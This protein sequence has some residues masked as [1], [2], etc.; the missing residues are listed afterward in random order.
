[1]ADPELFKKQ[2]NI[3]LPY[4]NRADEMNTTNPKVAYYCRMCAVVKGIELGESN[5]DPQIKDILRLV[6]DKMEKDKPSLGINPVSDPVECEMWAKLVFT[7]ADKRD[8]A[9][10]SD[11]TTRT[12][13]YN[14]YQFYD[15]ASHVGPLSAEGQTL[16]RY[17]AF[18]ATQIQKALRAGLPPPPPVPIDAEALG[19]EAEEDLMEALNSLPGEL[20]GIY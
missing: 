19:H 13:F 3:L 7:T 11:S 9:G 18:R 1:M 8:R 16:Q 2:K 10:A 4:L 15:V 6:A 5:L 20:L 14:A 12:M 17:G